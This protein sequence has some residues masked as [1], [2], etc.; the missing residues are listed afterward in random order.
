M[1]RLWIIED[2]YELISARNSMQH[3][4]WK[5]NEA[6]DTKALT[7]LDLVD[8]VVKMIKVVSE[9]K[10][11]MF[12][13]CRKSWELI[14]LETLKSSQLEGDGGSIISRIMELESK[15]KIEFENVQVKTTNNEDNTI[16]NK[17]LEMVLK[18]DK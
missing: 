17:G 4:N 7:V 11:S 16:S 12:I 1:T 10:I 13:D 2:S 9:G 6:L 15:S 18:F 3:R 8:T 5:K 14:T